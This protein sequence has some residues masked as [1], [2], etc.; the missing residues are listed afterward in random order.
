MA[1]YNVITNVDSS[2]KEDRDEGKAQ[3]MALEAIPSCM[4]C[5]A[6]EDL[7]THA[8]MSIHRD[9]TNVTNEIDEMDAEWMDLVRQFEETD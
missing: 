4:Y 8:C 1:K 9:D 6:V 5:P 3:R 7:V 2:S